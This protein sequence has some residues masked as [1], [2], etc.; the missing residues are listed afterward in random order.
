MIILY[1]STTIQEIFDMSNQQWSNPINLVIIRKQFR[2][3]QRFEIPSHQASSKPNTKLTFLH[4]VLTLSHIMY[5][6]FEP[7]TI[8]IWKSRV[9]ISFA[10]P[11][12]LSMI[13]IHPS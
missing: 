12:Q 13:Q 8:V 10:M 1:V 9:R 4:E 7:P 6:A 2:I 11:S 5:K 3:I